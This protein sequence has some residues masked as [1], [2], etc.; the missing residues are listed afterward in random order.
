MPEGAHPMPLFGAD[1]TPNTGWA[2]LPLVELDGQ[3][4]PLEFASK[5][6]DI[7]V[8]DLSDLVRIAGLPPAGTI[9]MAAFSRQGRQPRAYPAG[10]LIMIAEAVTDLREKLIS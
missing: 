8:R 2:G 5:M 4:W 3:N 7:P 10:K 1:R 6:L 9:R